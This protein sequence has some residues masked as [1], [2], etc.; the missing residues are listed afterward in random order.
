MSRKTRKLIWSAPLVAVFAV[1]SAL[2]IFATMAPGSVFANAAPDGVMNFAVAAEGPTSLN[3]SWD[4]PAAG[5]TPTGYRVDASANGHK[6]TM[7]V[8]SQTETEYTHENLIPNAAAITAGTLDVTRYYRVFALNSHGPGPESDIIQQTT[9]GVSAPGAV[10]GLTATASGATQINL[11]WNAPEDTGGLPITGY[12]IVSGDD[13]TTVETD[14]VANSGSDATTYPHKRLTA[15]MTKY[16][17]VFAINAAGQSADQSNT[18][19]ATTGAARRPDPPT[20][21]V[22]VPVGDSPTAGVNLYWL[23]P[24]SNGGSLISEYIVQVSVNGASYVSFTVSADAEDTAV[25]SVTDENA[26]PNYAH[27]SG[28]A[29]A[30]NIT[31]A[32]GMKLRYRI[33]AKHS[34]GTS[35]ASAA[36]RQIALGDINGTDAGGMVT[37]RFPADVTVTA[38]GAAS[39]IDLTWT[40][41]IRTGYRI[42]V[43]EDGIK[44]EQREPNTGLTLELGPPT[45]TPTS[46]RTA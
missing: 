18:A 3:L 13:A 26:A 28:E 43:S 6:W 30:A 20:A 7:L 41:T 4:A 5:E 1:V 17:Q 29:D 9:N 31:F 38:D 14:L 42:D 33:Q 36:S 11:S 39:R 16:Y 12:K 25:E 27:Q 24:A 15:K 46:M 19:T 2:A 23:E 44:W 37:D 45:S 32:D 8:A 34:D 40:H 22:A 35:R 10:E 21:V